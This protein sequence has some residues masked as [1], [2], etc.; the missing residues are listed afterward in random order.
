MY[1]NHLKFNCSDI[2]EKFIYEAEFPEVSITVKISTDIAC[3]RITTEPNA[4]LV[5]V[6]KTIGKKNKT[7]MK[8][9]G[10]GKANGRET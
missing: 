8:K 10:R 1:F 5:H 6:Y 4:V 3:V 2:G 9:N 7:T